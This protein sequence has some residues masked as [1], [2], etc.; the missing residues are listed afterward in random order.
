[1]KIAEARQEASKASNELKEVVMFEILD[2]PNGSPE[3]AGKK[4]LQSYSLQQQAGF[5]MVR[6]MAACGIPKEQMGNVD[7]EQLIGSVLK[8]TLAIETWQ[9]EQRNRVQNE[10]PA[11]ANGTPQQHAAPAPAAF[12]PPPQPPVLQ[13]APQQPS[14]TMPAGSWAP[15][16]QGGGFAAPPP[17]PR[18]VGSGK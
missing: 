7:D 2:G 18:P 13:A 6:L 17:P 5:R 12:V 4:V 11:T 10:E 1:L 15:P 8:A 14:T 9:G 16:W 3:F